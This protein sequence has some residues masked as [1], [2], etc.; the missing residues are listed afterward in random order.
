MKKPR[1]KKGLRTFIGCAVGEKRSG[2]LISSTQSHAELWRTYAD[3]IKHGYLQVRDCDGKRIWF[4]LT[5]KGKA[6]VKHFEECK[7]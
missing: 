6:H 3:L 2:L 4:A 1:I 5:E 7:A